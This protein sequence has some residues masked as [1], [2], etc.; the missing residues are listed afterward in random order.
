MN[1]AH[2]ETFLAVVRTGSF[3]EA[4]H[5]VHR[6]QSAVSRQIKELEKTL[7]VPVFERFGGRVSLTPAGRIL[8][9]EVPRLL[10]HVENM[11][12]RLDD[13][14]EGGV[15]QVRIGATLSVANTFLPRVLARFRRRFPSV[16]LQLSPGRTLALI[17]KLRA[18]ELDIAI[19]GPD[20]E[21]PDLEVT[22]RVKDHLVV[23]AP[24]DHPLVQVA[25]L[26][27]GQLDGAEFIF[28]EPGADSR[29]LM[30]DWFEKHGVKVKNLMDLW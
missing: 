16:G 18:N 15:G 27:P 17:E 4:G 14:N 23:V 5:S 3:T 19:T 24:P 2:L 25:S 12:G 22:L 21:Q 6:T 7:G 13:L 9:D 29:S 28:R 30:E 8:A 20:A 26:R 1:L 10:R 11:K